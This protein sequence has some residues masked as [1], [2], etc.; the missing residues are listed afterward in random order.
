MSTLWD[1]L[2]SQIVER[3]NKAGNSSKAEAYNS[4]NLN[5]GDLSLYNVLGLDKVLSD[6]GAR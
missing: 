3:I 2:G 1:L 5:S 6:Y 4:S